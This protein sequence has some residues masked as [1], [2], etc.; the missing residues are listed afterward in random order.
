[1][2]HVRV[3]SLTAL[4]RAFNRAFDDERGQLS[5]HAFTKGTA[6]RWMLNTLEERAAFHHAGRRADAVMAI[7][8]FLE[9]RKN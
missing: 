7:D 5:L 2:Q 9:A 6:L 8:E 1:M 4:T 3:Y